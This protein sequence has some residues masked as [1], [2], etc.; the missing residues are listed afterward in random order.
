M[1]SRPCTI[2]VGTWIS[3]NRSR[4]SYVPDLSSPVHRNRSGEKRIRGRSSFIARENFAGSWTASGI[5]AANCRR[6]SSSVAGY[7]ATA[8][9]AELLAQVAL[10]ET[11]MRWETRSGHAI[12]YVRATAPPLEWPITTQRSR[13]TAS[14]TQAASRAVTS[15]AYSRG[16]S[17]GSDRPTPRG[18]KVTSASQNSREE[19]P[20]VYTYESTPQFT[21]I[22]SANGPFPLTR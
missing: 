20:F 12:A 21:G 1:S 11:R 15:K 22:T 9:S 14:A 17:T 7:G 5:D 2:S 10:V 4:R 13:R 6:I 3:L 8:D 18:S 16:D 19:S